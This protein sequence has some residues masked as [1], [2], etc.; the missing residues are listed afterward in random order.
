MLAHGT[1]WDTNFGTWRKRCPDDFLLKLLLPG[2]SLKSLGILMLHVPQPQ[3][4]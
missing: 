3:R 1:I 4:H 2:V